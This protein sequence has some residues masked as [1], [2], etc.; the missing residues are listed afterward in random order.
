MSKKLGLICGVW[1]LTSL[2]DAY[3]NSTHI[4]SSEKLGPCVALIVRSLKKFGCWS[5]SA[6]VL[7]MLAQLMK[8]LGYIWWNVDTRKGFRMM[9]DLV[10]VLC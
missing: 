3:E 6:I 2:S 4:G 10:L 8:E 5:S 7:P 9:L 1:L